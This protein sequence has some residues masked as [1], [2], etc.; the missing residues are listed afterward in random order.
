[1]KYIK[2]ANGDIQIVVGKVLPAML[3][4]GDSVIEAEAPLDKSDR[5]FWVVQDGELSVD[6]AA[7]TA[8]QREGKLEEV[9]A[10]REPLLAEADVEINKI[11]DGAGEMDSDLPLW[12]SYR[13]DL[14]D[15]TDSYKADMSLLD[16]VEDVE[17]DVTWPTKP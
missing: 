14:R 5:D 10:C 15:I 8:K 13:K 9:R 11:M 3:E 4:E 6:E 12:R 7:K 2:K 17:T 1:M 16:A